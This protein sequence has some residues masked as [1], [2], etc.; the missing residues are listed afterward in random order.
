MLDLEEGA[1]K[2]QVERAMQGHVL[3]HAQLMGRY[4]KGKGY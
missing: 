2:K 4:E 3:A 1:S